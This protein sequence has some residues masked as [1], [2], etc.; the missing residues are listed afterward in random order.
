MYINLNTQSIKSIRRILLIYT[1]SNPLRHNPLCT[2]PHW[3]SQM[4]YQ[5]IIHIHR[6]RINITEECGGILGGFYVYACIHE[7]RGTAELGVSQ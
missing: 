4:L 3:T 2:L 1:Q 7:V 5:S 6:Y